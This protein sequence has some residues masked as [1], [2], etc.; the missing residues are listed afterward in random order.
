MDF[1]CQVTL[2][3]CNSREI[4]EV[5]KKNVSASKT[6]AGDLPCDRGSK[7]VSGFRVQWTAQPCESDRKSD[8]ATSDKS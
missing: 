4:Q 5:E 6:D 3:L 1:W 2:A 8:A 7:G